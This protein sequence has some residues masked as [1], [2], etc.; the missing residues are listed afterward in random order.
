MI[1]AVGGGDDQDTA[2]AGQPVHQNQQL[3]DHLPEI[4]GSILVGM[5]NK[6]YYPGVP[7]VIGFSVSA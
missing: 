4:W 6:L 1:R 3:G 2:P 7:E 5:V